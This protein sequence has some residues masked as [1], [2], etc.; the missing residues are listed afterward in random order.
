MDPLKFINHYRSFIITGHLSPDGDAIG[1]EIAFY[2]FLRD[3][4]KET[5]IVNDEPAPESFSFLPGFEHIYTLDEFHDHYGPR[6]DFEA[7]VFMECSSRQRAGRTERLTRGLPALNIDH[8]FDNRNYGTVNLVVP[9]AAACGEVI[10]ELIEGAGARISP[11][12]AAALYTAILTDTASFR[13]QTTPRTLRSV[14]DLIELGADPEKVA[15]GAYEQVPFKTFKLLARSLET[16]KQACNGLVTYCRVSRRMY[17]ETGTTDSNSESF[18]DYLR[19][20]ARSR[21]NIVFKELPDH[22]TRVNL[23]SKG[24]LDVQRVASHFG[25]GGHRNAAGCSLDAGFEEARNLVL[26]EVKKQLPHHGE[27]ERSA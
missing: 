10:Y 26:A 17:E 27:K 15:A 8:H 1:S 13:F 12:M 3:L 21:V 6:H 18:I 16:L 7:A 5:I 19:V 24:D 22:R 23:R 14:A 4:G 9:Q 25:G 20:I 2:F 11:E